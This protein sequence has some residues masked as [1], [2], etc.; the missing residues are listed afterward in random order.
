MAHI[1]RGAS[2]EFKLLVTN[3]VAISFLG[4]ENARVLSTPHMIGIAL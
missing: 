2:R 4:L 1:A 3:E